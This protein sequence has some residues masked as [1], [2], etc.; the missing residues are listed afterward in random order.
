MLWHSRR[1]KLVKI[2]QHSAVISFTIFHFHCKLLHKRDALIPQT[3]LYTKPELMPSNYAGKTVRD[4]QLYIHFGRIPAR[5][6]A[7]QMA[8]ATEIAEAIRTGCGHI[9]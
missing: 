6:S 7:G 9:N 5:S 1:T 4:P 8:S 3:R 2:E